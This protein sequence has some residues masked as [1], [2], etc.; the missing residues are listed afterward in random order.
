MTVCVRVSVSMWPS[1]VSLS[2]FVLWLFVVRRGWFPSSYCRPH[3]DSLILNR[4][5]AF[6]HLKRNIFFPSWDLTLSTLCCVFAVTW[7][8]RCAVWVLS[9]CRNRRRTM[10]SLCCCHHQITVTTPPPARWSLL[11]PH[12]RTWSVAAPGLL[13]SDGRNL[14]CPTHSVNTA[15][16]LRTGDSIVYIKRNP[17]IGNGTSQN[18]NRVIQQDLYNLITAYLHQSVKK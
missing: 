8:H 5:E 4:W 17:T 6:Q 9:V 13:N 11:L 16:P 7:A 10:T 14:T 1:V 18:D 15:Q 12:R 3:A 2:N